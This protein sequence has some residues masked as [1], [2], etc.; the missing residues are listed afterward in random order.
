MIV[1]LPIRNRDSIHL[2]EALAQGASAIA[3]KLDLITASFGGQG[4]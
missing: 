3:A 1:F 4:L 2:K